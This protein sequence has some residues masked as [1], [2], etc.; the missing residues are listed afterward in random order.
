MSQENKGK[1]SSGPGSRQPGIIGKPKDFM[2]SISRIAKEIFTHKWKMLIVILTTILSVIFSILG[3]KV[4]GSATTELFNGIIRQTQGTG[5]I[6]FTAIGRILM[7]VI[8]LYVVSTVF[9]AVQGYIMATVSETVTYDLRKSMIAKINRMPMSYFESRPYGEILSRINNDIDTLGQTLSQGVTQLLTSVLTM[10]GIAGIMLTMNWVLAIVVMLTVP[11]S[12]AVIRF[13]MNRSQKYFRSQ[14]K[15]V[16]VINGQVEEVYSGHQIVK[17]YNQEAQTAEKFM[18]ENEKLKESAWKSQFFSGILFPFMRFLGSLGYVAVVLVGAYMVMI[19]AMNVGD[20]QAFTQY[21]NRFTQPISQLAQIVSMMQTMAAAGE[22]VFEFLDE[23][24]ESQ[25]DGEILNIAEIEGAIEFENVAFGYNP[26][27]RIINDFSAKVQPGQKVALVGPTGAGKTTVV[28]LLMRFYDVNQG[29][30]RIDQQPTT[31]FSRQSYQQAMA[32]VLQDTWLFKGSIMENIRYGRLDATDEE[33][34]EAAKAARVHHF[35]KQLPG[36]YKFEINEEAS[37]VSQGQKQLLTI[38]RALLADR[39][40]LIL[41]EATSSVD[42]RTEI[43]I[44]EAMDELMKGRT[45]F[46]IAH[47]LSTI[48]DA[49]L[50][51]YMEQGDIVEQGNHET[52]IAKNGRYANLYNSQ[53][54]TT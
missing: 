29:S 40:I 33:V 9:G 21:V 5:S 42:T 47:R 19:G 14:Q 30:I 18:V 53:F 6:D 34:I 37:N 36:A 4:L 35:I 51:L 16:G 38:A 26:D 22:R 23:K 27:Q 54:A 49:D 50:I 43:L 8:L 46:V 20:I 48:K 24:E 7:Y 2:G 11:I 44:Q 41:D 10:I 3:P 12:I 25:T 32:M 39:P 17:A 52:L 31:K 1:T 13:I 45:S 28:K 15:S